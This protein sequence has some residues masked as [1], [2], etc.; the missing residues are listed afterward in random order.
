MSSIVLVGLNHRTSAIDLRACL[1]MAGSQLRLALTDLRLPGDPAVGLAEVA[2]LSTCNRLEVYAVGADVD[3]TASVIT[4]FLARIGGVEATHLDSH[5][6]CRDGHAAVIHLLR[7][8]SGLDSMI[9]GEP[10][11]LG[12]VAS[13]ITEAQEAETVGS[14]L[15]HLFNQALHCGKRARAETEIGSYTTS[16][17]HAAAQVA[18]Y[19]LNG[20]RDRC[21]L[22]V[23]AGEMAGL[24]ARSLAQLG[25][26]PII[27]VNRTQERAEQL[28]A[29]VHG[30]A[31]SWLHLAEALAEADVVMSATNAPHSVIDASTV[32]DALARRAGRPLFIFDLAVPRDVETAVGALPGVTLHDIDH[33][34][35]A[36]DANRG[37]RIAATPQVE[38]IVAEEADAFLDWLAS[39]QVTPTLVELRRRAECLAHVELERT[40]RRLSH[41]AQI[42]GR[43]QQEVAHLAHRIVHKLL[44]QPT[45]RLK[46]RAA[47]GDGVFYA[48]MLADLFELDAPQ[49]EVVSAAAGA[50]IG[51]KNGAACV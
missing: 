42:D 23:G 11:I 28:A 19:E 32:A 18:A 50:P 10:Q 25:A 45:V 17:S 48:H 12:Q 38:Q 34:R 26:A 30:C 3:A 22:V 27:C 40:L 14:V 33:L 21:A 7:V 31:R 29:V 39:R 9:L 5:L 46:A 13:A 1:S 47:Q 16:V 8:A 20:L 41:R 44:H 15:S 2:I 35:T 43:I 4:D 37:R 51:S 49:H 24:A 6:Y 36:V